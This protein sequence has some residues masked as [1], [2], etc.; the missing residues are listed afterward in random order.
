MITKIERFI[1]YSKSILRKYIPLLSGKI[2]KTSYIKSKLEFSY[3]NERKKLSQDSE[4]DPRQAK[5]GGF[6][7][8][9]SNPAINISSLSPRIAAP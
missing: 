7:P 3:E 5:T 8:T 4:E 1:G 2:N 6:Q 9:K